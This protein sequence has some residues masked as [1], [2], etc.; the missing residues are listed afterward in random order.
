MA[1]KS[2]RRRIFTTGRITGCGCL[3]VVA[4]LAGA[5][6]WA[7]PRIKDSLLPQYGFRPPESG[8]TE[9]T[10]ER[11]D[12]TEAVSVYGAASPARTQ[13]LA[14]SQAEGR[15]TLVAAMEGMPVAE[16]DLLVSLDREALEREDIDRIVAAVEGDIAT[17]E[18]LAPRNG[19][20]ASA[21]YAEPATPQPD[22]SKNS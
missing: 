7:F 17:P 9:V 4:L 22:K 15:I 5:G 3:L 8:S 16:G 1:K 6:W 12:L 18:R 10:V 2:K 20:R 11:G 14:F 21:L 13:A 19:D